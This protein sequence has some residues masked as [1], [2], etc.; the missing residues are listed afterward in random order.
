MNIAIQPLGGFA[1]ALAERTSAPGGGAAAAAA[2]A[3]GHAAGAMAARYTTGA[4]YAAQEAAALALASTLDQK[5]LRALALADLDASAYARVQAVKADPQAKANA[6]T[7]ARAIPL[8]L[9]ADCAVA[10]E[11]L[12]EFRP[13]CNPWLVSDVDV[14]IHLLTGAGRAAH[15]TLLANR[16]PAD[17]IATADRDLQR[18]QP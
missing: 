1:E 14:A 3:L 2:A 8:E 18:L 10:V 7:A 5:R 6:E 16:P 11:A 17:E 12:R 9:L 13:R 15:A 4:K